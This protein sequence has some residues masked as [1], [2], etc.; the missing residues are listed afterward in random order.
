MSI[1]RL[2]RAGAVE[3]ARNALA[4]GKSTGAVISGIRSRFGSAIT[5]RDDYETFRNVVRRA[6]RQL[7]AGKKLEQGS[8][9]VP[10]ASLPVNPSDASNR[11]G[12]REYET[13]VIINPNDGGPVDRHRVIVQSRED[14]SPNQIR[15]EAIASLNSDLRNDITA[16]RSG[17]AQVDLAGDAQVDVIIKS[18][19]IRG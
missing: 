12:T 3:Y 5:R 15:T 9:P 14:L 13:I 7:E 17:I 8:R 19:S 18:A 6:Q 11:R 1:L 4:G 10:A 2:V 16:G